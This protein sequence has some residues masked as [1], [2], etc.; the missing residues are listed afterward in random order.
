MRRVLI[1]GMLVALAAQFAL[2]QRIV[3]AGGA[4]VKLRGTERSDVV[5]S[6]RRFAS[7]VASA[8]DARAESVAAAAPTKPVPRATRVDDATAASLYAFAK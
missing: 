4:R 7:S 5:L 1:G 8:S 2:L 6:L 3:V